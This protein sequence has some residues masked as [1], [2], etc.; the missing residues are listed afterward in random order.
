[1]EYINVELFVTVTL[2][3]L[4]ANAITFAATVAL[5]TG[6]KWLGVSS[7]GSKPPEDPPRTAATKRSAVAGAGGRGV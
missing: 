1:M 3:V 5:G 7:S 6:R 4:G 2:A